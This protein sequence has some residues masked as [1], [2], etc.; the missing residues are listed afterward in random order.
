MLPAWLG[1]DVALTSI[2]SGDP[3]LNDMAHWPFFRMQLDMLEMVLAKADP[4]LAQYYARR[5]TTVAQQKISCATRRTR[6]R[7]RRRVA[8][9]ARRDTTAAARPWIARVAVRAQHVPRS[10]APAAG[11]VARPLSQRAGRCHRARVESDDGRYF[12][13][14]AQHR[15]MSATSDADD[16]ANGRVTSRELVERALARIA[17]PAG[18]GARAFTEGIRGN[19][20]RG[21]RSLR[22]IARRRHRSF[23]GGRLAGFGE[24]PF[25]RGRRRDA[26]RLEDSRGSGTGNSRRRSGGAIARGRCD[27]RRS[28]QHGGVRVRRG[29]R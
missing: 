4:D 21:G 24:G 26:R 17:D 3:V 25:R 28:H 22:P 5:L 2:D 8:E 7:A 23:A 15:L 10:V 12:Q 18:E 11:G 29:W 6:R 27:H 16:L 20:A 19:G 13:R 1:T 9:I 14:L